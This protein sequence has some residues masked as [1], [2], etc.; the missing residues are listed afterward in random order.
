MTTGGVHAGRPTREPMT[1]TSAPGTGRDR[2]LTIRGRRGRG[3]TRKI[4]DNDP[5]GCYIRGR[6][7]GNPCV[8]RAHTPSAVRGRRGDRAP[9]GRP[10]CAPP[11]GDEPETCALPAPSTIWWP[12]WTTGAA[13]ITASG[14]SGA[15]ASACSGV[16]SCS[17]AAGGPSPCPCGPRSCR[18]A[19]G[20]RG[21]CR[22]RRGRWRT[23]D[24]QRAT[25]GASAPPGVR[26]PAAPRL[27]HATALAGAVSVRD[28]PCG[29][30][31][32]PALARAGAC[33]HAEGAGPGRAGARRAGEAG[34]ARQPHAPPAARAGDP[35]CPARGR[36]VLRDLVLSRGPCRTPPATGAGP[37]DR[38][39]EAPR[40][41]AG[42]PPAA[43]AAC[44]PQGLAA[45]YGPP[46][47]G[48][49]ERLLVSP[50]EPAPLLLG[51]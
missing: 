29:G 22:A 34:G 6:R 31:P 18:G 33:P 35:S 25:G 1:P 43:R 41:A 10:A 5:A 51:P 21:A 48:E 37:P 24:R 32:H 49:P 4:L 46:S 15:P 45:A 9:A 42:G 14:G 26:R 11:A 3:K 30:V 36:G 28:G 19:P 40:A 44:P 27:R 7:R 20:G 17:S 23:R 39:P 50:P 8:R 12:A 13:G 16:A 2:C 47:L 38:G